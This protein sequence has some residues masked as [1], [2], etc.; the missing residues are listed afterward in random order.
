MKGWIAKKDAN[1]WTSLFLMIFSGAVISEAFQLEIGTPNNPGSGFMIFGTA[2]VLGL[3]A[4]HQFIKS[5]LS[6][7]RKSEQDSEKINRG[8]I[9]S[10]ILAN[11]IYIFLLQ[12]VGY[13]LCTFLLL[14]FLFQI[15]EKGK[16][17]SAVGGAALTSFLSYLVFSRILQLNLPRGLLPFF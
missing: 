3:L 15:Q 8:R 16:W 10:V 14:S 6:Q 1:L 5:L 7:K 9:V 11:I 17:V 4:L 13:L 2:S 12:P